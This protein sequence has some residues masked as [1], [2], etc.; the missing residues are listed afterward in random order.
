M[1]LAE[2]SKTYGVHPTQIGT[3]KRAAVENKATAFTRRGATQ[4]QASLAGVNKLLL[5]IG[6][7]V[8]ERV[9]L[10]EA[11]HQNLGTQGK[12]WC[13]LPLFSGPLVDQVCPPFVC[14]HSAA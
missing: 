11:S 4:Q 9:I 14:H 13:D 12:K 2:S 10:A 1:T 3:W 5:K 6:H 7:L 8:V